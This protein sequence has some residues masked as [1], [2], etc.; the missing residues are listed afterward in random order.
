[1]LKAPP[2][3]GLKTRP[4]VPL[5]Q[6]ANDCGYV[7][8]SAILAL[9]G[10][11]V[12]VASIKRAAGETAR[13]LTLRQL[14]DTCRRFGAHAEAMLFNVH[15]P[16][17]YP[18]PSI[19]LLKHG[20]YVVVATRR[21]GRFDCFYPELGWTKATTRH[22]ARLATGLAI[23]VSEINWT[24]MPES[25][26]AV[27]NDPLTTMFWRQARSS[28]GGSIFG[29]ACLS[30]ALSLG[31]PL[32]SKGLVDS[33]G[34]S[35]STG[36]G[37]LAG[38]AFILIAAVGNL[39]STAAS[40]LERVLQRR[41][42]LS[43][44]STVFDRLVAMPLKWF[45]STSGADLYGYVQ[46]VDEQLTFFNSLLATSAKTAI[47]VIVGVSALFYISPWLAI[48][49]VIATALSIAVDLRYS[50]K[51]ELAGGHIFTALQRH[52]S[53]VIDVIAQT[54]VFARFGSLWSARAHFRKR[55]RE[56]MT[57]HLNL[58]RLSDQRDVL[59][60]AVRVFEQVA[61]V[62]VAAYFTKRYA[63]TLGAFV[64]LGAYKDHLA[65]SLL[66]AFQ[67]WQRYLM[68]EPQ[69]MQARELLSRPPARYAP[70]RTVRRGEVAL[71][72]VTFR[73]GS[74]ENPI[75]E[76]LSMSIAHGACVAL[77]GPSGAGKTTLAKLILGVETPQAGSVLVD[78]QEPQVGMVGCAGVF[79]TDRLLGRTIRD[80]VRMFRKR[81][82]DHEIYEALDLV[83]MRDF[84]V[85][86]PMKLDTGI[87]EGR[88]GLSG[89][90]RQ[91]IMLARA[92]IGDLC[93]LVLDEAT[94]SLD[95]AAEARILSRLASRGI[96]LIICAHRPEVWRFADQLYV[97]ENRGLQ[98]L[99]G[100]HARKTS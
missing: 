51:M 90:Q 69:R 23:A 56:A 84:V 36:L 46:A 40:A 91:R 18:S 100:T 55:K 82:T 25:T 35:A 87:G 80:N 17:A 6:D 71:K 66:S 9:Y 96:T 3:Q 8:V 11:T 49:G 48:P 76:G 27:A 78:G 33:V 64:A 53:F 14:R 30:E 41:L 10:H 61:F 26:R 47:T 74:L 63:L 92:L 75:L 37:E 12:S 39:T 85:S 72:D 19:V 50:R 20:H 24:G 95:V 99:T 16:D 13:G 67:V 88:G 22:L 7:C 83:E 4:R 93:L 77:T 43:T 98:L 38:V 58:S 29:I 34:V 65:R 86:L 59:G 70:P 54:P 15:K 57:S 44:S 73:Y 52:R 5:Q 68:L 94:S 89:G 42:S 32:L 21:G 81:V 79:Q 1:M 31:I 60:S 28:L 97:V 62:C 2:S 45:N